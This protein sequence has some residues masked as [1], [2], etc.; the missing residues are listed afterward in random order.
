[1]ADSVRKIR[2]AVAE[3]ESLPF[4][5]DIPVDDEILEILAYQSEEES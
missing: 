3:L 5:N 4:S 2:E 1:V